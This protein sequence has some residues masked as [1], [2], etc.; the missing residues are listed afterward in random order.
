MG[1]GIQGKIKSPGTDKSDWGSL[2]FEEESSLLFFQFALLLF[3]AQALLLVVNEPCRLVWRYGTTST[4]RL[5]IGDGDLMLLH[6]L[7]QV[8]S[9]GVTITG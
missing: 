1:F 6:E 8:E 9:A 7:F 5:R 2:L 3:R 4:K